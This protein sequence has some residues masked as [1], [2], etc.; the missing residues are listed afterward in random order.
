MESKKSIFDS[1][2]KINVSEDGSFK[3]IENANQKPMST[4]TVK[5]I[6][7]YETIL[8]V[9]ADSEQQAIELASQLPDR[10]A[11]E[12]EQCCVTSEEYA[13]EIELL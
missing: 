6:R 5:M 1:F 8:E 11:V 4:Y 10:Y 7:T 2:K 12:L 13:V 3:L 9:E